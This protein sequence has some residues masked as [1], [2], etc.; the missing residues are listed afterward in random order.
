M[1]K[2]KLFEEGQ[3]VQIVSIKELVRLKNEEDVDI[4]FLMF[5]YGGYKAKIARVVPKEEWEHP[6]IPEYI[7]DVDSGVWIWYNETLKPIE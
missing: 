6:D 3:E 1:Y 7:L 2:G 4:V 5:Q